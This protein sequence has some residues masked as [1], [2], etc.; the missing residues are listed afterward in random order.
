MTSRADAPSL[1]EDAVKALSAADQEPAWLQQK[2]LDALR[3]YEALPMP[4]PRLEEWRRT[5]ITSLDID[6]ALAGLLSQAPL[7]PLT[8]AT[9]ASGAHQWVGAS[10]VQRS[11]EHDLRLIQIDEQVGAAVEG[12][13]AG[14]IFCDLATAS[15]EHADILQKHL[16]SLVPAT[17][18]KLQALASALR[19]KGA[20]VYVPRNLQVELPLHYLL[21]TLRTALFPHLLIIAEEGSSV[22]VVQETHSLDAQEQTLVS[23]AVEIIAADNAKVSYL[24]VQRW[25]SNVYNFSTIRARLGRH[26]ELTAALLGLGSRLTKT[27]L[28]V[29]LE[30]EGARADLLGLSLGEDDQHF[31]YNTLQDHIAPHTASDLLF[32]TALNDEASAVWYGTVR[33]QKGASQSEASQTSRNLLLSNRAKAAPIPVLEIEAYDVLRCSHGATVG[34]LDEEQR[35]YLESRGIPRQEAENL[36]V[37]AFFQTVI[38]RLPVSGVREQVEEALRSRIESRSA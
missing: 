21:S 17:E 5:D 12:L 35:F 31:D 14:V 25:G 34:P 27:R 4:D 20:L 11:L 28:E 16:N 15:R 2:R 37:E 36:L 1:N 26:A 3:A 30:G 38:D 10:V 22:T 19:R 18:W 8:A 32:K 24:D 29:M 7:Q 13:P 23:Q 33:I 6:A 9:H